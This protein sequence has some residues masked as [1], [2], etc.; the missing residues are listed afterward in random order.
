[1]KQTLT[2]TDWH[3]TVNPNRNSSRGAHWAV[4]RK[5]HRIDRD[6]AWASARQAGWEFMSGKVRLEIVFVYPRTVRVDADNLVARCKG[7]IDGLKSRDHPQAG[8]GS[9]G[10]FFEDDDTTHLDLHVSA[11][12]EKGV[13]ATEISLES[14]DHA[15]AAGRSAAAEDATDPFGVPPANPR[16]AL[17]PEIE[18]QPR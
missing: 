1:M 6:M 8:H 10:G 15:L 16:N 18:G 13:K 12:V 2:I 3:P 14:I 11:R 4:A 17:H 9:R 5:K 7:L